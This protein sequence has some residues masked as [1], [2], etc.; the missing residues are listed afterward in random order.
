MINVGIVAHS[1]REQ[2][3]RALAGVVG[4]DYV[5]VDRGGV[6]GCDGNHAAVQRHLAGLPG[7]WSVI[8]ED[9]AVVRPDFRGQVVA[10]L[11]VAPAPVVSLYLGRQRPPQYQRRI[12]I[13]CGLAD[14][15]DANWLI[16]SRML[17]AVGYAI[18]TDLLPEL[19]AFESGL[20][21]DERIGACF[22][23]VAFCWPSL[24]DHADGPSVTKHPDGQRRLPGRTA[25]RVGSRDVWTDSS[26]VLIEGN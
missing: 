25:W 23:C 26:V 8:L 5:S 6:L 16:S 11:E 9:D 20:P 17:H 7:V 24:V 2:A 18:R 21:A 22:G 15:V 19:L 4:A 1:A 3:A 13:V 14:K 12:E 10:A